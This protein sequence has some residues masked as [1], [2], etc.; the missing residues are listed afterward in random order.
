MRTQFPYTRLDRTPLAKMGAV[1]VMTGIGAGIGGMALALILH[2]VQHVAYGY[3]LGQIVGGESFLQGVGAASY[4]RRLLVLVGCGLLAGIGWWALYRYGRPLVSIRNAV[5]S[6]DHRMPI[7]ESIAHA[8]LQIVTV[9]LGSPLGRETAP[10]EVGATFTAWLCYNAGLSIEE[11]RIVVACGAAAGLAAVYN[12]PLGGA[13]FVLESMLATFGLTAVVPALLT[14]GIAAMIAWIGLGDP[15]FYPVAVFSIAPSLIAWSIVTGPLFGI[16]AYGFSR[17]TAASAAR[18]P[19]GWHLIPICVT[20]FAAIGFLAIPFPELLGNGRG[21][22]Q[23][24]FD[25][26]LGIGFAALLLVLR[27]AVTLGALRAGAKGGLLT[28]GMTI[29]ALLAAVLGGLWTL[30]WP[31][32][33]LGAF[34]VIGAAA[35]LASSMKIPMTAIALIV[36]FTHVSQAFLFPLVLAVGGSVAASY[37]CARRWDRKEAV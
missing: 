9:A 3:S 37:A 8:L 17:M 16:A 2:L 28:P 32:T 21:P 33:P 15:V 18:A 11:S 19:R 7:P 10:R 36:E 35:F 24:G 27:L 14:S 22:I 13:L 6:D 30:A 1:I 34:A 4:T 5:A 23:L 12:V 26:D 20:V 31:G 25:G 29:G